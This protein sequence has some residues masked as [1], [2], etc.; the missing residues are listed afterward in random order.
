MLAKKQYGEHVARYWLDL[1]R[2]ADTNGMHKDFY[3]NFIAYR[4]WV[5]RAFNDNLGYDD[6]VRYQLAGDLYREPTNDQLVATGFNRLHL[7]IDR[8]TALPEESFFKNV[9]DRVTAVGTAFMGLTVH[10]AT[11][12]E[13]KY[14]PL[15][16]K[17]FYSCSLSSTTSMRPRNQGRPKNGLQPPSSRW[18]PRQAKNCS[19]GQEDAAGLEALKALKTKVAPRKIHEE[20]TLCRGTQGL[21]AATPA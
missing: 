19:I 6:F 1:V 14:D 10:C 5:I 9:V 12:H 13:H 16:Q 3:R 18:Q 2:F 8:G 20:E 21:T 11:C 15:T 7:I 4:D 17:D